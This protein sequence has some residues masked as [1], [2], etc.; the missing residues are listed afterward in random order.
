MLNELIEREQKIDSLQ[1]KS[2]TLLNEITDEMKLRNYEPIL[3][4]NL[5]D[6]V[7]TFVRC[8]YELNDIKRAKEIIVRSHNLS[9]KTL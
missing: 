1:K 6:V 7:K 4:L 2:L 9:K 3:V 8:E 5:I